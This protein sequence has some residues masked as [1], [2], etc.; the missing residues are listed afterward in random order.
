MKKLLLNVKNVSKSFSNDKKTFLAVDDVTFDIYEGECVGIVG[1]SGCGKSTLSKILTKLIPL[2]KGEIYYKGQNISKLKKAEM[3]NIRKEIQLIFQNPKDSFNP[4]MKLLESVSE[5]LIHN[6]NYNKEERREAVKKAFDLV[7]LKEDYLNRYISK[8]SGGECQR[9]AIARS[10]LIQ[11]KLLICDEITS[12]LD[13]SVQAQIVSLLC[14]L[15]EE[16]N[17]SYLF[18]THDLALVTSI[19]DRV[20]VMYKGCIV[21]SGNAKDLFSNP[22]HPYTQLLLSCIMTMDKNE[23]V[24]IPSNIND[25]NME[26]GCKFSSICPKCFEECKTINPDI[27]LINNRSVRCHLYD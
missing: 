5:G 23:D 14:D 25:G 27:R 3:S 2:D 6:T 17:M 22:M 19:C 8:I 13:V 9:A 11:P 18:I 4:R 15:K 10:I 16:L 7:G 21:E 12:A 24:N 26:C 20:I 1:E